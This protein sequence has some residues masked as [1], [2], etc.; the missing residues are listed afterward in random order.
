MSDTIQLTVSVGD[1]EDM[2]GRLK[3]LQQEFDNLESTIG[4]YDWAVG[5]SKVAQAL[6]GFASN[7]SEKR[8]DMSKLLDTLAGYAAMGAQG[9]SGVEGNIVQAAQAS[10]SGG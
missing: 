10:Q 1:L 5:S 6:D 9:Y 4:G 2:A 8:K 7:W 3:G